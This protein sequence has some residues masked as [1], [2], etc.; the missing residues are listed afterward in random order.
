MNNSTSPAGGPTMDGRRRGL[1]LA[2]GLLLA[3]LLV[4][5]TIWG[6]SR[7]SD[8]RPAGLAGSASG[9]AAA[10]TESATPASPEPTAGPSAPAVASDSPPA[11]EPT[12]P[13]PEPTAPGTAPI[14]AASS[15]VQL[16]TVDQPVASPVPL[17][18]TAPIRDGVTAEVTGLESVQGVAK[19]AGEV[20]GPSLRFTVTIHNGTDHPLS[21]ADVVV[22]VNAGPE[23][24]PAIT[25]SGPDV[26]TFPPTIAPGESGSSTYV[27]LVPVSQRDRVRILVNF[28]VDSPIAAFEGAAPTEGKP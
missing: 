1:F 18:D 21:T 6:T 25:L 8:N 2:V 13:A 19:K 17:N 14:A 7:S 4:A 10:P 23:D 24:L 12:A 5:G 26:T 27:F 3:A 20:A 28:Q 15:D 9:G 22:N 11:P 16:A